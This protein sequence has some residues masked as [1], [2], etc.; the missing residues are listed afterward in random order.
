[1]ADI[2][3]S[4]LPSTGSVA[5]A[6]VLV[7]NQGGITKQTTVSAVQSGSLTT[8]DIAGLS[9]AAPAALATAPVVGLSAFA[10]RADHQHQFPTATQVGALGATAA[11]GG[12]LTGNY[13]NPTLAAVTTA[14]SGVGSA[15][16]VPVLSV[17]AKGR[18]T[19][20]STVAISAASTTAIT[21]LTGDVTA[22]GPGSVGATLQSITTAQSNV[23]SASV[24]PVL[25]IDAKGRVTALSTA[26]VGALT[27]SQIAGLATTAPVALAT[28][29]VVGLSTF[30]ARADHQHIFPSLADIGAQ[31]ALTTAAPLALNL[32]GTA[33]IYGGDTRI[34]G[35][36]LPATVRHGSNLAL[37]SAGTITSGVWN[38]G[39]AVITFSSYSGSPLVP[40]MSLSAGIVTGVIRTV[41]SPT[42]I[43]MTLTSGATSSGNITVFNS[44]LTNF[45]SSSV[46]PLDGRTMQVGDIVLLTAQ[47]A[48]AQNGPWRIDSIGTGFNMSRPTWFRGTYAGGML[49]D[50]QYGTNNSAFIV[51]LMPTA[52]STSTDATIGI[53]GLSGF[54]IGKRADCAIV[55]ANTFSGIQTFSA[56]SPTGAAPF[57]FASAGTGLNSTPIANQCEWDGNLF[58]LTTN[59]GV[60]TTNL[61]F[62]AAPS[63]ATSTGVAGQVAFDATGFYVCVAANT[64]RKATLATF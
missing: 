17:D 44:S 15:T 18:V 60:R 28:A 14:Q 4:E 43:T 11:A 31:A 62:V 61:A 2:K 58:Y 39:S 38:A 59:A 64:W 32:G 9:T 23:G 13:P 27:T 26:Q 16:A 37:A 36:M 12:D 42:Q 8:A 54:S 52:V 47:T 49:F 53:D 55:G 20:L 25:S 3:I 41:D 50:V 56:N 57:K 7:V 10:A 63:T 24:I 40:G 45:V 1:M 51:N 19:A 46:V 33:A 29:P 35:T 22:T 34:T 48:T 21:A 30:A 5:G 6:D